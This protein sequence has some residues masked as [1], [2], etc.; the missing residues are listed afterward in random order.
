[1][2]KQQTKTTE[3]MTA[4]LALAPTPSALVHSHELEAMQRLLHRQAASQL[5]QQ[6]ELRSRIESGVH[7]LAATSVAVG[8]GRAKTRAVLLGLWVRQQQSLEAGQAEWVRYSDAKVANRGV[9]DF[10]WGIAHG[11]VS[12]RPPIRL[13]TMVPRTGGYAYDVGVWDLSIV[14]GP[15]SVAP[16]RTLTLRFATFA[17]LYAC[18]LPLPHSATEER[19]TRPS[20]PPPRLHAPASTSP[21]RARACAAPSPLERRRRSEEQRVHSSPSSQLMHLMC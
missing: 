8:G 2:A 4:L 3:R 19:N 18:R 14:Q 1:M 9:R 10:G 20:P 13:Y 11:A 15:F 7:A 5:S 16:C 21:P 17:S 6:R 12:R